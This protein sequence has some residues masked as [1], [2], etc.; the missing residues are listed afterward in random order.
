M[1]EINDVVRGAYNTNDQIKFKTSMSKSSLCDDSDA[2]ILVS[3]PYDNPKHKTGI[4][5]K[6]QKKD[7]N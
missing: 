5:I 3:G 4:K 7:K 2:Y 1:V 6:Q